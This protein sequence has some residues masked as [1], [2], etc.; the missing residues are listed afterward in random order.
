MAPVRRVGDRGDERCALKL[1]W[2]D[3]STAQEALVLAVWDGRRCTPARSRSAAGALLLERLDA[4]RSLRDLPVGA[5]I[6]IAGRLLRRLAI[7]APTGVRT[8][9][10]H[11]ADMDRLLRA[12]WAQLGRPFGRR[13]LDAVLETARSAKHSQE[14]L[15]VNWDLHYENVLAGEREPWLVIDPKVVAGDPAFGLAQLLWTRLEEIEDGSGVDHVFQLLV[16]AAEIDPISARAWTILR[17]VDYWLWALSVG[18]TEDP[19]LRDPGGPASL[20]LDPGQVGEIRSRRCACRR[21][22]WGG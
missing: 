22:G 10:D 4:Q 14:R 21:C 7:P 8:L 1:A 20:T 6:V 17:L 19:A 16:E 9:T 3:A 18:F 13:L 2:I 15:L 11:A 5:A 12:R